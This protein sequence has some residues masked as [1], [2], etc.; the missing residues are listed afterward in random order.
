[1]TRSP[2]YAAA[3]CPAAVPGP[4]L[5]RSSSGLRRIRNRFQ[6]VAVC[7]KWNCVLAVIGN[8][9]TSSSALACSCC[10]DTPVDIVFAAGPEHVLHA[11]ERQRQEAFLIH[12]GSVGA[13]LTY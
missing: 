8:A 4:V 3:V 13:T 7:S 1:M 5:P 6:C 12:A 9:S 2:A 10:A 11:V